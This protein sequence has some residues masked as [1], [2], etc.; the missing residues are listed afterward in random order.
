KCV[1]AT[2]VLHNFMKVSADGHVPALRGV[3]ANEEPL[4]GV[5]RMGANNSAR[6]AREAFMA[7][8]CRGSTAMAA[9]GVV[10]SSTGPTH[11]RPFKSHPLN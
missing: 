9:H 5:R 4:P 1:K 7:Y 6:D 3:G 8:H 10:M 2:S 11:N